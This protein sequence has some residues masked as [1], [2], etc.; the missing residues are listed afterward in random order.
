MTVSAQRYNGAAE[1]T[2]ADTG[3]G[4][5]AGARSKVFERFYTGDAAR[6]AGLGLAI[7]R[8]LAERMD[9]RLLLRP[10]AARRSRSSCPRTVR[11]RED[12]AGGG[13][14]RRG[15]AARG[16]LRFGRDDG[17]EHEPRGPERGHHHA[18]AGGRGPGPRGRLRPGAD[19][20]PAL[21]RRRHHP[22]A[23][24]R[25]LEPARGRRRGRPGLGLRARRRRLHR[26]ERA[27]GHHRRAPTAR[28]R[29]TRSTWSSSTAT[30][31]R[32]RSSGH[33]PNADV[34][35]LK[36]DPDGLSLTPLHLGESHTISVGEPV[37]AIGS[38]FG[39]RQ[40]LSIGVISALD[41]T[42]Q[43]LT[44]FEIG[45][46]IQ[47]DAA[48]NPGN[49]GGPLLDAQGRVIGINAQIKSQSG[50]GEGVGFAIPVDAVRRSLRE[51][52]DEGPRGL[53]L[54]GR[55][56]AH[57][58]GRSSPSASTWTWTPGRSCRSIVDGSPAED[59]DLQA[60]DE[61]ITFQGQDN[62]AVGGDLIVAVDGKELTARARPRRRD[63]RPRRGREDRAD[64][65]ARRQPAH[66]RRRARPPS[67]RLA[68]ADLVLGF[69]CFRVTC[70]KWWRSPR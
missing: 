49:S 60:G 3:P 37:A 7:A 39:E 70:R 10:T 38:P 68:R 12:S 47:T 6:G 41:R 13:A 21:A 54:P 53:R 33:D 31:C 57:A 28:S 69:A 45:D 30:A 9:G 51:L 63:Q 17:G 59:A 32:R 23:L 56:D 36:V 11:P 40:S 8:E 18:G 66:H 25:R 19:L 27:R 67:G 42:I 29:P 65:P 1:L 46:A 61:D 44:Q 2:V 26:H 15:A 5:P 34:A 14:R 50:G 43:S 24:Q 55:G 22:V 20:R 48:I 35:L 58:S 52:R 4:L 62:I 64:R 16:G